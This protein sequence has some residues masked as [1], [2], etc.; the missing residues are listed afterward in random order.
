MLI[1]N[2]PLTLNPNGELWP[3]DKFVIDEMH[4]ALAVSGNPAM[5]WEAQHDGS[6]KQVPRAQLGPNSIFIVRAQTSELLIAPGAWYVFR[7]WDD[8]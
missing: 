1:T 3:V 7:Y 2:R 4:W 5:I 8:V 6:L